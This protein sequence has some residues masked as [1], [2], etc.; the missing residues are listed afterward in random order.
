M[1]FTST[2]I[3]VL[4]AKKARMVVQ[5]VMREPHATKATSKAAADGT[6]KARFIP[7]TKCH[8]V[9][10]T[11]EELDSLKSG[12]PETTLTVKLMA[13]AAEILE[14][15]AAEPHSAV[16]VAQVQCLTDCRAASV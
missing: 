14:L 15:A 1:F 8:V 9:D 13:A 7:G 4:I 5:V 12:A 2:S 6:I 3:C 16:L 10:K 11:D